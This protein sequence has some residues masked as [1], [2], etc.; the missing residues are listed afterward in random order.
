[1]ETLYTFLAGWLSTLSGVALG[2]WLV[3]RTKRDPYDSLFSAN[4]NNGEVFNL[5]DDLA[6]DIPMQQ[7]IPEPTAKAHNAFMDQFVEG[8]GKK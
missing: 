5:D 3:Y 7:D 4:D 8:L 6:Q 2:G 1:M